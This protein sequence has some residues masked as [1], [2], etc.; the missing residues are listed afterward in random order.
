MAIRTDAAYAAELDAQDELAAFRQRFVI[1]DPNLIY[2][3]GNSLGRLP[4]ATRE[5][6]HTLIDTEWGQRLI[7]SWNEGWFDMPERIGAKIAQ[8]IG[9]AP[10]E[11]IVADSTSVNLFKLVVGA[12]RLQ[13][14]RTRILTDN[15]N[16]PSDLYILQGAIELLGG[17][18]RLNI[19]ESPDGVHGPV[20][21]IHAALDENVALLTLSHTVFKSGYTYDLA[22]LTAAAHDAGALVLWDL[23]HS[24]GALPI[25][26]RAAN[27]DLAVGCTYKYLN[28]GPGAPAFLYVRRDL[29]ERL[30]NPISGWMGQRNLFAFDLH[31]Q[32]ARSIRRYLT[33]TP[34]IVSLALI[35]P[36]VDLLLEAGIERVRAK[37]ERQTGYLI[38]LWEA[39]LQPVGFTLNSPHDSR[40]RGS[41]ISLGHPEG[42]RIDLALIN[43]CNV[44]PDFRAPDNIRLGVA[45]LYTSYAELHAAAVWMRRIVDERL[46]EK[47]P[48]EAPVVT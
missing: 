39:L 23:S 16:F 17:R 43:D 13:H 28:G 41:H 26:L 5:R 33:G 14:G 3:D 35:E 1:D 21:A 44:L 9:A 10:D 36:G 30:G 4:R 32:P 2:L 31:Y 11:V 15:L 6:S 27:A 38:A 42:L 29:Q 40:W 45:P 47:Y 12:L 22:A 8:L 48:R 7:R 24:V 19:L 25:D 46:Y 18:H 20:E 37:S 34:P